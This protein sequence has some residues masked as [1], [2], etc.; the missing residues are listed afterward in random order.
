MVLVDGLVPSIDKLLL[1]VLVILIIIPSSNCDAD[2]LIFL[3]N[4]CKGPLCRIFKSAHSTCFSPHVGGKRWRMGRGRGLSSVTVGLTT[5][6]RARPLSLF[7]GG[8]PDIKA[9]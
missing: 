7:A 8:G 1:I 9:T 3:H 5:P 6:T 4:D 2:V